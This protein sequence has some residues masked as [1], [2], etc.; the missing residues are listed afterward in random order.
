[1]RAA[2]HTLTRLRAKHPSRVARLFVESSNLEKRRIDI[3]GQ[4][5]AIEDELFMLLG[6]PGVLDFE[7]R[8]CLE[9][10]RGKRTQLAGELLLIDLR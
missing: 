3:W 5:R 7:N 2:D 6:K 9:R 1:V 8:H 4:M 10:L